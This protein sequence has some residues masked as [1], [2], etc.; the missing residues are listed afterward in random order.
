MA[1]FHALTPVHRTSPLRGKDMV[2][3]FWLARAE[4]AGAFRVAWVRINDRS[5]N[6]GCLSTK[7]MYQRPRDDVISVH[8]LKVRGGLDYLYGLMHDG[9][10]H[11]GENCTRW[12]YYDNC[13]D[14]S[15]ASRKVVQWCLE[16]CAGAPCQNTVDPKFVS[17]PV[18]AEDGGGRPRPQ[19]RQCRNAS[20]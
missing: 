12:V 4:R 16:H 7:G 9:L 2:L 18:R 11:S 15:S 10:P 1:L 6:M 14:L 20:L 8:N 17:K 13:R 3:G 19:R 5:A